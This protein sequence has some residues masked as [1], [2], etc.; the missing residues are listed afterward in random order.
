MANTNPGGLDLNTSPY[1]D[2]YDEDK[3]FA[4]IL[5]RPGRAVQARE[6]TQ[7]QTLQ[8]VQTKR[9]AEYFFKQGA[10]I[11]GCEQ[12]LDVRSN[13]VKL[14]TLYNGAEVDV[15]K[16]TRTVVYG[17][18][19]GI[20]AYCGLVADIEGNDPKTIFVSYATSGTQVLTVNV[21]PSTLMIGNNITFST[22][23]TGTI[24]AW[25]TD[26]ITGV[27]RIYVSNT[28]GT[29]SITTANTLLS[30]GFIQALNIT[31]VADYTSNTKFSNSETIFTSN[32]IGRSYASAASTNATRNIVDEGLSTEQIYESGSKIT[33]SEG[34]VYIADHFVKHS[35]QSIIL[36]KYTN[37]PSYKVGLV[38]VKSFVDYISDQSLVDNA[39]GTPN[40]QAPGADRL[41]IDTT[42]V[43][44]ALDEITDENEFI[45]LVEIENGIPR[46]RKTITVDSKIEDILAK[47]TQEESGNYTLDDPIVTTR[48]HLLNGDNGGRYASTDGGNTNLLLVEVDPFT[49]YVSGYRNQIISK[50]SIPIEKG[51]STSYVQQTNTQINYGQ[52]IEVKELVGAWDIM[53]SKIV[54]LYD[55][56]QQAITN[57]A[58]ST[59]TVT[60]TKIGTARVRS[61]EYVSGNKGTSDAR[62][63][64]YLYEIVMNSGK[65]FSAVR[66]IYDS[67]TPKRFA[68]IVVT[69]AGAVLQE[70]SFNTMIFPLPYQAI[71]TIRDSSQN[72][73]TAFR[74]KKKFTVSFSS[75]VATIAT[76][77][78]TETFVGTGTLNN[79]QKNDYYMVVVNNA[80]ANVETS[81]LTGTVTISAG[82]N[83]VTGSSTSFTT[84]LNV[85][86]LIKVNNLTKQIASITSA[87]SLVLTTT[88]ATGST[89]NTF[90][91][92]IPSGSVLS[93]SANGGK[94]STRTVTASSPGTVSIDVQE[95]ATFTADI[96]VS[97][98]RSA[99]K[100]KIKTL[101]YATQANINPNTHPNGISG[102]FGLGYGD[103]YQVRNIYQSSSFEVPASTSNTNV[104][105]NYTFDNGQKD[106]AYE[107]GSI[108]PITGYSPTGRLLVV[109]DNFV[110]DTSQGIGYCS[111]DSY[112]INDI[113]TSNTT[114][115]TENIPNFLSPTTKTFYN[116]R[117]CVD[118]RPIKTANTS[119]N[120]IDVGTYQVPTF[121]LRIPESGSDFEA[122]MIYYKGRVS[123]VYI[124][125]RGVFGINDGVPAQSGNQKAESPPTKSDTLEIAELI[126]PPYPS[127]PSSVKIR[128]LK[129]KRFTMRDVA[130]LSER[131][132]RLEYYTALSF[133]EKQATDT[134]ELD[135]DGLNRF[136]NG[137]IVDPF[138]GWT[139][140]LTS[141]DS[142]CAIDKTNKYLTCLQDNSNTVNFVYQSPYFSSSLLGP[143]GSGL[144][145]VACI[146]ADDYMNYGGKLMLP[147]SEVEAGG[148]K[149][150]YASRSLKLAEE[151]NFVW[152][153]DLSVMP[154]TDNFFD[155]VNDPTKAVVYNDD[156]GAE[157]WKALVDA[158]NT[159]VAPL[160]KKWIGDPIQTYVVPGSA[161]TETQN[162]TTSTW[163]VGTLDENRTFTIDLTTTT[164]KV[165][166][167]SVEQQTAEVWYN[168]LISGSQSTKASKNDVKFDRV[169][170]V[171]TALWMRQREFVIYAKGLKNNS[172][173]YA[174]FDGINVTA[175]CYQIEAVSGNEFGFFN[176]LKF[177]FDNDGFLGGEGVT[178]KAI[179]NGANTAQPLIV[180]NNQIYLLFEVPYK[181][182]YTGTREFKITD[183]PTNSEGLTSTFARNNIFAQG[184]IQ[185]TG[186]VS[187]NSR[188][189]NVSFNKTDNIKEAGRKILSTKKV[190]TSKVLST[191]TTTETLS[192]QI[193]PG[194][195]PLSQSFYVDP[196]TYPSGF[197]LTSIDLFF[198]SK[199]KDDNRNVSVEIREVQNGF[200]APHFISDGDNAVVNNRLIQISDDA[201]LATKFPFKNP[202]Y[203]SPGNDYCFAVKPENNDADFA[204]W[205]AELG[206]IDISNPNKQTRIESAYNSGLLFT[207]SND[208]TWTA[209]QNIDMKFTMRIAEFDTTQT[210]YVYWNNL[211]IPN[212][213]TYD[214]LTPVIADQ[215]L[216]GTNIDFAIKTSDDTY[217]V[218][219]D[220]T[221][222]KN[223]E[224]IGFRSRKQI[225]ANTAENTNSFKSLQFRA[226]LSTT[227][228]YITPYVDNENIIFHFD[229]NII[230][231]AYQTSVSGTVRYSS[232]SNI[233]T[234][235]GT[236]FTTQVFPG[237]YAKF[238][239]QFR[240]ISSISNN[241]YLT[242]STNFASSN[243]SNQTMTIREEEN[244]TGPYSSQARYITKVVTLNDGFEASDLIV[245]LDVN[246]P[247]GTSIKVYCK[248]LNENDSDAFDDKFYIPMELNGFETTS[249][250]PGTY[251]E[252]KYVIP[253]S[254]KTGGSILLSGNVAIST[255]STAVSG[256][257]TRFIQDLKI[258]DIIAVG[259]N[260]EQKVITTIANNTYLTVDSA[261]STTATSQDIFRM[262]NNSITYI[263]PDSR[264]FQGYKYFAIKIVFLSSV[265]TYSA[266]IKNLRG[267]ALA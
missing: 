15:Q 263:T 38:P 41:K 208:R 21:A 108:K 213:F 250:N 74:F 232:G 172:R 209:K 198:R 264:V 110:H 84:Q 131:V 142:A 69:T 1:F 161:K 121:G 4:R 153:G 96:I 222:I 79:T 182:F 214:G 8:Q 33:I 229:K 62:Y 200:P 181:K 193:P 227:D 101:N 197:Y 31:N 44:V 177:G 134:T 157:N 100:E 202:I 206:A 245:Y 50:T 155:T 236:K 253:T 114:I 109:F 151:L 156:Q 249:L 257:S 59:A 265:L 54:D 10:L 56:A 60:G 11:D 242:V 30:T 102:P 32:T 89:A 235:T 165:E 246:R 42:L 6:L 238:G 247:A 160:N 113:T 94:G 204:I 207:S 129:N 147:W 234:G 88:H 256:T 228:K 233:V 169:V 168:Q 218:D 45:T 167:S 49:S 159:E 14:Q 210:H 221:T 158:W 7:A 70:T 98:D 241:E 67:A 175:N 57:L 183:S 187:I 85:G 80:G 176:A 173:V 27:N 203:L 139:V 46:K 3:K 55:T 104:S 174:F 186:T 72:I 5:Y 9:F 224:R 35:T 215:I 136:K 189:F 188:P 149:Q 266:K 73:E 34:V 40:Y 75:G 216:P 267:I 240:R 52:Y 77:V 107:H 112:P 191:T 164:K 170:S 106:Y 220:W 140:A 64:L 47:R 138:V 192:W 195:D 82:S 53:E 105:S 132:E 29:L 26:P 248:V 231:N 260:R 244:P 143:L 97:I 166:V 148:L 124:N 146:A 120:P 171:E 118:F 99:A 25:Y 17:A 91:K 243:S 135:N 179:A 13:F 92:I 127:L 150:I 90:T 145:Y 24:E 262:L 251:K 119:L 219:S 144:S 63:Y 19:S 48:E 51:L 18:S 111:V 178:W 225:S 2:D 196:D 259:S 230:N 223:Y 76:D 93:L 36:D 237:E 217:A 81:T 185:K 43:K 190:E 95:S 212:A 162:K 125:S 194:T 180:K 254:V 20:K 58:H 184:I 103:I 23:N 252:E 28:S 152:T 130:K 211:Q 226:G 205:V 22:G 137:I 78:V 65:N 66:S 239:T 163:G 154:Y 201:S 61:I 68:D 123:K 71:K 87:T 39:Q 261:F 83:T 141:S 199:S 133:L 128:L 258:G 86:D 115:T 37:T 126:I 117:D 116:L 16:F 255:S 12:N 122:D